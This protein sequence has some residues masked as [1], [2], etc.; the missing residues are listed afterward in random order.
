LSAGAF[1]RARHVS[2]HVRYLFQ[3]I[4]FFCGMEE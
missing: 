2:S 1:S 4:G 3:H